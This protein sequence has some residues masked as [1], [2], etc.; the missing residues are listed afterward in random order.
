[1][2]ARQAVEI[3]SVLNSEKASR[4]LL[5]FLRQ[6]C[7][8]CER[9]TS[10]E[11]RAGKLAG[12]LKR[13]GGIMAQYFLEHPIEMNVSSSVNA[14]YRA[15]LEV[16][17]PAISQPTADKVFESMCAALKQL[18]LFDRAGL[19]VYEP[20]HD[21]LKLIARQGKFA[22]SYFRLGVL[23]GRK[24]CHDGWMLEHG[25]QIIRRDVETD[26]SSRSKSAPWH[27]DFIPIAQLL[28]SCVEKGL[29]WSRFSAAGR[30]NSLRETPT[31]CSR[32][33]TK[34]FWRLDRST[35]AVLSIHTLS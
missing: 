1:L 27:R 4:S 13:R 7:C 12:G 28:S 9:E 21:A 26:A 22:N 30:T 35:P 32:P 6:G 8:C 5:E 20:E 31:F 33:R 25:V 34:S 17:K 15:L 2:V 14:R 19:T 18:V 23:L 11:H 29:A 24:D 10:S 3:F 16:N